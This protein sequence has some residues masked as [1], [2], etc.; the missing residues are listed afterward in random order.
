MSTKIEGLIAYSGRKVAGFNRIQ[1]LLSSEIAGRFRPEYAF[2]DRPG[3]GAGDLAPNLEIR[4]GIFAAFDVAGRECFWT[5][6]RV[7]TDVNHGPFPA[8]PDG[9]DANIYDCE[10]SHIVVTSIQQLASR[11]DR[12]LP[13]FPD[14]FF[15]L[16]LVDE[17]HRNMARSWERVFE[18]FLNAEVV[19]LTATRFRG[20]GR[21][22]AG[23]RVYAYLFGTSMVQGYI[24]QISVVNVAPE[25]ISFTYRGDARRHTLDEVLQLRDEEWFSHGV[26]LAP[27]CNRSIVDAS[28]Q[29]LQ[30]LWETGTFYQLI[31]VTCSVDYSLQ[32]LSLYAERGL[33]VREIHSNMPR[34]KIIWAFQ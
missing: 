15:D 13:A 2:R 30:H 18:R 23:E 16:T 31:A 3:A 4:R 17:G 7:L 21:E 29:W 6:T 14:D 20:D 32:V 10:N 19:S 27:E 5:S 24:K 8:V 1:W 33:Q 11:A 26:A 22:I 28:I 25:E 34:R 9:R 12:R